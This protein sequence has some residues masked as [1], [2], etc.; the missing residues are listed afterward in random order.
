MAVS[1][2]LRYEVLRRDNHTCRYCGRAA[3]DVPLRIDHVIPV[4][5]GGTDEPTNLVTACQ[6]CNSGKSS[7]SPDE[8]LVAD[9]TEAA[10][11]WG[12]ALAIAAEGMRAELRELQT[13]REQFHDAWKAWGHVPL[14][15]DW[16]ESVNALLARGLPIE[17]ITE[18]VD[19]AMRRANVLPDNIFRYFCGIAWR[20]VAELTDVAKNIYG[21]WEV[22]S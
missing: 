8:P 12:G 1:K 3:P 9:V 5:L 11:R 10:L 7:S 16:P 19:I 2:R 14:D 15:R 13:V 22:G 17:V 18:C 21:S 20:K 6:D 4:A